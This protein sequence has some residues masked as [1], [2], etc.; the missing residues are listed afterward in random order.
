[1]C[2]IGHTF[3]PK[4][5]D[6]RDSDMGPGCFPHPQMLLPSPLPWKSVC[7]L[8]PKL[9]EEEGLICPGRTLEPGQDS[10][11]SQASLGRSQTLSDNPCPGHISNN[12][13]RGW[14]PTSVPTLSNS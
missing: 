3:V 7:P 1:M 13:C 8:R 4:E 11:L 5:M 6:R 14:A 9:P 2:P 12:V 10:L